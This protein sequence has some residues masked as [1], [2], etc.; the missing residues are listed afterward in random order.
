MLG[1]VMVL[2][3]FRDL[4][5]AFRWILLLVSGGGTCAALGLI[6]APGVLERLVRPIARRATERFHDRLNGVVD[7]MRKVGGVRA[8][9]LLML[10]ALAAQAVRIWT[11]WWCA[12]ALGLDVGPGDLFL[13]IPIVA[14]AAGLPISIG[15]LGVREGIGVLLLAPLGIA[16]LEA[17]SLE[18]L[19]YLVGVATSLMGG[20]TFILGR[21]VSPSEVESIESTV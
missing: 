6:F 14:V 7:A 10:V 13:V 21:E 17:F 12:Q 18:L 4:P 8:V 2:L 20:A 15:G 1:T 3:R 11:H 16:E 9:A 5:A 19:A